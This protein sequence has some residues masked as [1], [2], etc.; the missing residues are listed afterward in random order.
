M[1]LAKVPLLVSV[2]V[3]TAVKME[4]HLG[5]SKRLLNF[6]PFLSSLPPSLSLPSPP[7]T[8]PF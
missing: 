6:T 5:S 1:W 3:K 4:T 2:T 7:H 8:L